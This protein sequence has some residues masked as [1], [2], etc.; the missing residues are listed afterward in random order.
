MTH[1]VCSSLHSSILSLNLKCK[2]AA[3]IEQAIEAFKLVVL[4]GKASWTA[5]GDSDQGK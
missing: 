5:E 3:R 1:C 4:Q 2:T